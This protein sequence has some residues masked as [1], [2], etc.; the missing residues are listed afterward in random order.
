VRPLIIDKNVLLDNRQAFKPIPTV[1]FTFFEILCGSKN[2]YYKK[3][4]YFAAVLDNGLIFKHDYLIVLY[5][6]I[7][8]N[9]RWVN[10]FN[11]KLQLANF[12]LA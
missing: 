11:K 8:I 6:C 12:S 2:G 4:K 9:H 5:S 10:L 7:F 3:T 1:L